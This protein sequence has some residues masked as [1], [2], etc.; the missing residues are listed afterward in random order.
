MEG[1]RGA[2]LLYSLIQSCRLAGIDP[3]AYLRDVLLRAAS[4]PQSQI[5]E[6][7]PRGLGTDLRQPSP[8]GPLTGSPPRRP[9]ARTLASRR[10]LLPHSPLSNKN[11]FVVRL[12]R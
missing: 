8:S 7:T 6:L 1:A 10:P 12:P 5:A 2:A 9:A 3:F 11:G 4:H